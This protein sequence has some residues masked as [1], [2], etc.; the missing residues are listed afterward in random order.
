MGA[1]GK[2][3]TFPDVGTE[4]DGYIASYE[5]RQQ[6]DFKGGKPMTWDDGN[7]RMQL[8]V[9][10]HTALREDDD[11]DGMRTLYVKGNMQKAVR[12]AV[13]KAGARGIAVDGRLFVRYVSDGEAPGPKLSPPKMYIAKY[14]PPVQAIPDDGDPGPDPDDV[15]F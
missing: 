5:M 14:A 10:L 6:T 2:S 11:D 4:Y 1:G 9:T 3:A 13:A 15:P 12:D 8:V 7:P